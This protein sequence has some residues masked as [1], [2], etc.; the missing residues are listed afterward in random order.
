MTIATTPMRNGAAAVILLAALASTH[1]AVAQQGE[2]GNGSSMDPDKARVIEYWTNARRAAA[3]PRD[4]VLDPR[5]LA[6]LRRA[7]GSLQPHGHQISAASNATDPIALGASPNR[8]PG[9]D[10]TPPTIS[11]MDPEEGATIGAL[12]TFSAVVTDDVS[13]VRSVTFVRRE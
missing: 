10:S 1:T 3:T 7:D 6:Y 9:N 11:N 8:G 2:P 13:G 5:G 12:Q 4:L